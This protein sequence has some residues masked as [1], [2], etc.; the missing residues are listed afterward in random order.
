MIRK[1]ASF[2]CALSLVACRGSS[3]REAIAPSLEAASAPAEERVPRLVPRPGADLDGPIPVPPR[4]PVRSASARPASTLDLGSD[5]AALAVS[6][7]TPPRGGAVAF[8]FADDQAGWVAHIPD[9]RQLPALAYGE[10]KIY[11][12]GGFD[13]VNFYAL[14]A[15][16]GQFEWAARNLQDN[17][18]TAAVFDDG[19]V[20]FNTESCTLFALDASTGKR[21]WHKYLGDP[22]LAQ[23]A[24]A[25]GLVF[26]AHPSDDG[27]RLSAFKVQSGARVWSRTISGD[28]LAAPVVHGDS[29]YVTSIHGRVYR[30]ERSRGKRVWARSMRATTA[31]WL[32]GDELFVSRRNGSKE[33]QVV[34]STETGKILREHHEKAG[35]HIHDVPRNLSDWRKVWA[36]E[37]SRPVVDRGVRYVAMGG[38]V[39]ATDA[40]SGEA[41]WIRRYAKASAKRSVGSVALAGPQVVIATRTGQIYGLDVDTGYTLWAYDLGHKVVAEP[42]VARGWVYAAT[43]DGLVIAL[44]VGDTTL[45]GWH[46][47]GGNPAHNGP[48]GS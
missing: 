35:R 33:Q 38:E 46:M 25:D 21:L 41:L 3:D 24:V 22:T 5:R 4:A 44:H 20:I 1:T 7:P 2:V 15:T 36:F 39:R 27:N 34:V 40:R 28:L 31:P 48:V 19:R 23:I 13:S 45:D 10:D 14:S 12:S 18:P 47:F 9:S 16:T 42:I 6:V 8:A 26:A 11:V 29:V 30:F 32:V 17:G 37:G 43:K